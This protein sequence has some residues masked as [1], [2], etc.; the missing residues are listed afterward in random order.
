[1]KHILTATLVAAAFST[2]AFAAKEAPDP[3]DVTGYWLSEGK[4]LMVEISRCK[5]DEEALC[6]RIAWLKDPENEETGAPKRDIENPDPA[7]RD[8]TWCGLTVIEGLKF[9][10]GRWDWKGGSVYNPKDG[11]SYSVK[12][13]SGDGNLLEIRAYI[14]IGLLGKTETWSRVPADAA[15]CPTE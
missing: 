13:R 11:H 2:S 1:M 9:N 4:G 6:G 3:S 8:R 14:G 12:L 7:L 15:E 10:H 5:G